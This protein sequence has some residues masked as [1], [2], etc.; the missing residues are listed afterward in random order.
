MAGNMHTFHSCRTT[1]SGVISRLLENSRVGEYTIV[2]QVCNG[3]SSPT[4]D[5]LMKSTV[6]KYG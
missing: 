5:L 2:T 6:D 1:F 4:I 3:M